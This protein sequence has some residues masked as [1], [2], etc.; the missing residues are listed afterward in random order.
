MFI[1]FILAINVMT[2]FFSIED[3]HVKYF[4]E[5]YETKELVFTWSHL[6][7]NKIKSSTKTENQLQWTKKVFIYRLF[8]IDDTIHKNRSMLA[9]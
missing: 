3:R 8:S 1:K 5:S 9:S 2:M 6:F 4:N 7:Y